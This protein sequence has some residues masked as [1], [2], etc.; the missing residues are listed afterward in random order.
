MSGNKYLD[1]VRYGPSAKSERQYTCEFCYKKIYQTRPYYIR[2]V[3]TR[4]RFDRGF[5]NWLVKLENPVLEE[6]NSESERVSPRPSASFDSDVP[7]EGVV[8]EFSSDDDVPLSSIMMLRK[9]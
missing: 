5:A 9:R 4:H 6:S 7:E 1:I 2:H 8:S 3:W